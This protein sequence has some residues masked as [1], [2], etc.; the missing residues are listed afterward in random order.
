MLVAEA[1]AC[2]ADVVRYI[3]PDAAKF[4]SCWPVLRC[5][6]GETRLAATML[7]AFLLDPRMRIEIEATAL[8]PEG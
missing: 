2:T 5:W 6:F 8:L 4:E 3:P 1:G 7:V